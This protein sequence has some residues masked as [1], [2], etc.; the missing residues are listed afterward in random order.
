MIVLASALSSGFAFS[1]FFKV[2]VIVPMGMALTVG[3]LAWCVQSG[4]EVL[5]GVLLWGGYM[6]ALSVGYLAGVAFRTLR[7]NRLAEARLLVAS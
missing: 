3:H 2:F 5:Q 7:A 4:V 6:S 1:L